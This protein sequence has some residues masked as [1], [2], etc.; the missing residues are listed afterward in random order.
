MEAKKLYRSTTDRMLGGVAGGI[1]EYFGFDSTLVRLVFAL[2]II[3]AGFGLVAYIIAWVVIPENPKHNSGKSGA[4]EIKEH[5]E[6]VAQ[7]IRKAAAGHENL[8]VDLRFWVGVLVLLLGVLLL[9]QM[10]FGFHF[11]RVFWPVMVISTGA[12]IIVN[13]MRK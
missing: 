4:E 3:S 7:D 10:F 5:A 2:L 1:A 11:W 12:V 8:R 13:S 6:K 9:V